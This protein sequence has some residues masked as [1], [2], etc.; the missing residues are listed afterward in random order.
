LRVLTGLVG[1]LG[2]NSHR[3]SNGDASALRVLTGFV[4][5]LGGYTGDVASVELRV[6][7]TL[8]TLSHIYGK[9]IIRKEN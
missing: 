6:E 4:Y 8:L 9:G 3:C 5:I 7:I 2:G 1:I